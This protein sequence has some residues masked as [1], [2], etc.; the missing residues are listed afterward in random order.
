MNRP[1]LQTYDAPNQRALDAE[2]IA[3]IRRHNYEEVDGILKAGANPNAQDDT[4]TNFDSAL[5]LTSRLYF[6]KASILLILAGAE[7]DARNQSNNTPLLQAAN[8]GFGDAVHVLLM[9]GANPDAQNTIGCTPLHYATTSNSGN[10][11][12]VSSLLCAGANVKL[13]EKKKNQN[14]PEFAAAHGVHHAERLSREADRLGN[15]LRPAYL[16]EGMLDK[17]DMLKTD[18]AGAEFTP[19]NIGFWRVFS[20]LL[21]R[22]EDQGTPF[23]HDDLQW[24]RKSLDGHLLGQAVGFYQLPKAL[25]ALAQHGI[26]LQPE[27]FVTPDGMAQ[28]YVAQLADAGALGQLFVPKNWVGAPASHIRACYTALHNV[29]PEETERQVPHIHSLILQATRDTQV[30]FLQR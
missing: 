22:L 9:H 26:V 29:L 6:P 27:D 11:G 16:P 17:Q 15:I 3:A 24:N 2:L 28:D 12:G 1:T 14:V 19:K 18:G 30:N 8:T 23:T 21:N 13:C 25:K 5:H 20:T 7:V 10:D 4:T